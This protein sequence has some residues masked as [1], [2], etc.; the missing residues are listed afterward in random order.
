LVYYICVTYIYHYINL[1]ESIRIILK[2]ETK[3]LPAFIRRRVS[4]EDIEEEFES[5]LD[6][7]REMFQRE[8]SR[9][10]TK[11]DLDR[12]KFI[13]VS[14][15]IDGLHWQLYTSFDEN[16]DWHQETFSVLSEYFDDKIKK[17]YKRI[18]R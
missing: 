8:Y 7:A 3:K 4:Q 12:Y 11:P 18:Y 9:T 13:V 1:K 15:T 14:M 16:E 17:E 2:E 10:G 6:S 5:S